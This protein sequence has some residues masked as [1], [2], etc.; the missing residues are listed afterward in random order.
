GS[1]WFRVLYVIREF[2]RERLAESGEQEEVRTLHLGTYLDL[3]RGAGPQLTG[4]ERLWWLDLL[5]DNHDNIRSAI[6][7]GMET[8]ATDDVLEL[9]SAL[10]RFWQPRGPLS[11]AQQRIVAALALPDGSP[12]RYAQATAALGGLPGGRGRM[13]ARA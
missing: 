8:G 12:A 4:R 3:V 5:E 13:E 9:V 6:E 1:P 10:W 7:R 2:A 11:E